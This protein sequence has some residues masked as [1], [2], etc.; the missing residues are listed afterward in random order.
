MENKNNKNRHKI[1]SV[2]P[3]FVFRC[4][5]ETDVRVTVETGTNQYLRSVLKEANKFHI[6][7]SRAKNKNKIKRKEKQ[8][9]NWKLY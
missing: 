1:D 2:P 3:I 6:K 7:K 9:R 5:I 8:T 4:C